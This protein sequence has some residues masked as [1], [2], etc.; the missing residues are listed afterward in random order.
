MGLPDSQSQAAD[1]VRNLVSDKV[2]KQLSQ[3]D[4]QQLSQ[5][6]VQ[7]DGDVSLPLRT[8][9]RGRMNPSHT[10]LHT[11]TSSPSLPPSLPSLCLSCYQTVERWREP[12][13]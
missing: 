1:S 7:H 9:L 12:Y 6:D 10:R 3:I 2:E 4:V 5:I 8:C 13:S 11:H